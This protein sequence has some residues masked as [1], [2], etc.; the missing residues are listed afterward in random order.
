MF[1][2]DLNF[3][4]SMDRQHL[5]WTHHQIPFWLSWMEL[6]YFLLVCWVLSIHLLRKKS[7]LLMQQ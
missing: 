2:V 6:G 4:A 1:S 3:V 7:P 5:K